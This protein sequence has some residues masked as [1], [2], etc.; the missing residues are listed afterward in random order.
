MWN[1]YERKVFASLVSKFKAKG[2]VPSFSYLRVENTLSNSTSLYSFDIKKT[3][4][5]G[6][7]EQ[8]LDRNDLF[9]VT[10]IGMY[11]LQDVSAEP[12]YGVLQ[13]YPN[14]NGFTAGTGF[15]VRD[16]EAIYNGFLTVK[17]GQT[18]NIE[19]LP[20]AA[21]RFVPQTR[22]DSTVTYQQMNAME[23]SHMPAE[24]L[25]LD[26]GDDITIELRHPTWSGIQVA[27]VASGVTNKVVF[28][29]FGFL[30]RNGGRKS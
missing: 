30:I 16:L 13:T 2:R 3:S 15:N 4:S 24:L 6:A 7:S 21:F 22:G 8:K 27:A 18:T 9:V 26:G 29:P 11:L 25:Y 10:R 23:Y 1:I 14:A 20:A 17:I 12:G 19:K 28:M 5:T